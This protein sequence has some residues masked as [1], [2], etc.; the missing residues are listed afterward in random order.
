MRKLLALAAA[1]FL[2]AA[3]DAPSSAPAPVG[4]A[5]PVVVPNFNNGTTDEP[6]IAGEAV[7][8]DGGADADWTPDANGLGFNITRYLWVGGAGAVKLDLVNGGTVTLSGVPAGTMLKLSA[9]KVY[10]LADGTT[11]TNI[12]ALY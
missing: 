12:V 10:S 2:V 4:A 11:A 1:A 5:S 8:I 7:A 6:A 9:T 3:C